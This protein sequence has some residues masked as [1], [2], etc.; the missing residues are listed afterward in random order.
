MRHLCFFLLVSITFPLLAQQEVEP[1]QDS[2]RTQ[3]IYTFKIDDDIDPRMNRKVKLA[4]ED[5]EKNKADMI[6]IEMDTYGGAVN[7]ADDIRTMVLETAVPIHVWINKDAASAGALISIACDS[8]YMAPGASIGAATVVMGGGGE[9][10]PDKYQSYMRSMMRSTAEAKGRDPKIAEAMVDENL[11][12]EGVSPK[13]TVITFSVSEAITNGFAEG[14]AVNIQE[15]IEKQGVG[16]YDLIE[17]TTSG[18]ESVIAFFLN[19]AVSGFLIL[20]IFAGIYFEIQTPGVGFPLAASLLAIILYF[21]P[22]YL[23]GLANNW[24]IAIF[25]IGLILLAVEL[26]VIPG[27]GVFGILGLLCILTGL[28]LGMVPNDAFDFTFVPSGDLFVALLTVILAAIAAIGLIFFFAPKVNQWSAF[29]TIALANTQRRDEGFTSTS[30]ADTLLGKEG[31]THTRLMP[32]GKVL[33]DDELYD[34]YSRGE[35]I[36]RGEKIT[37]IS[38]EGTSIRVKKSSIT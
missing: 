23:T 37:V 25:I 8:I 18:V 9:A 6:I 19:P 29:S 28:T 32:S 31:V 1:R 34:A 13:G 17:Y 26:F 24:E 15:V 30:Y 7:D 35:F 2:L 10:A 5:A 4:L 11:E 33:I 3:Q 22:Y 14:E 36:D 12:I 20:I 38:T 27:F 21:I 16:D